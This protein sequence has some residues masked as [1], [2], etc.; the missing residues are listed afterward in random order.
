[1]VFHIN[2]L[3]PELWCSNFEESLRFYT[4]ILGFA[5]VQ[6]RGEDHH[7]YLSLQGSQLMLASWEQ[8]GTWE[9]APLEKPYGRGINFQ[10]LV[11]NAREIHEAVVSAG[12]HN[13]Y[14]FSSLMTSIRDAIKDGTFT[15]FKNRFETAEVI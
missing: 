12:M 11:E 8:D 9:P 10:I 5:V 14:F 4:D 1:M 13:L 6:R 3:V 7:A 2:S 15:E